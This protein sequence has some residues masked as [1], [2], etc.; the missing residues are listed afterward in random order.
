MKNGFLIVIFI[1]CGTVFAQAQQDTTF[2]T[3]L[4]KYRFVDG[5]VIPSVEIAGDSLKALTMSSEAGSSPL[6][7]ITTDRFTITNFNGTADFKRHDSTKQVNAIHIEAMGYILD[8]T[9]E[10][11]ATGWT[12]SM[13]YTDQHLYA[14][15]KR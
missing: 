10:E 11:G 2:K 5:S 7:Y 4:G 12:W 8:G 1:L 14:V 15:L 6:E 13:Y 9:K 3:Y